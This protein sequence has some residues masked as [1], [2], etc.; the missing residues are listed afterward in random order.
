MS[1]DQPFEGFGIPLPVPHELVELLQKHHD[2][3]HM[4]AEATEARVEAFISGLDV[5]GLMA[6]RTI[7]NQGDMVKSLSANFWDGQLI[8]ILRYVKH[9]DPA[10][11]K[12]PLAPDSTS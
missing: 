9:V 12:D 2:V 6:L 8:S 3:S 10:T 5:D 1:D 7:L 4:T 11:G